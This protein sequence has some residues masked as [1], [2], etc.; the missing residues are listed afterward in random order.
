MICKMSLNRH[1]T[2]IL[3]GLRKSKMTR[4]AILTSLRSNLWLKATCWGIQNVSIATKSHLTH[5]LT[6]TDRHLRFNQNPFSPKKQLNLKKDRKSRFRRKIGA[7]KASRQTN[8]K[9]LSSILS[10]RVI[11]ETNFL[12][13]E[14]S[15][16][17]KPR[18]EIH[19]KLQSINLVSSAKLKKISQ[20]PKVQKIQKITRISKF[21]KVWAKKE[22]RLI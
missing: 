8:T 12:V 18:K 16:P 7:F 1:R 4:A 13:V 10:P 9:N 14:R 5:N 20:R 22:P 19:Y 2:F 21:R 17:K 15:F 3:N 11:P 6:R